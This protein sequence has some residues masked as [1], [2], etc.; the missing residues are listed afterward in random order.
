MELRRDITDGALADPAVF[1]KQRGLAE[2]MFQ[3]QELEFKAA[4]DSVPI[5]AAVPE[6][7]K[8]EGNAGFSLPKATAACLNLGGS[9]IWR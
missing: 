3:Y 1:P 8:A 7:A 2:G 4:P 6:P 9:T 5:G